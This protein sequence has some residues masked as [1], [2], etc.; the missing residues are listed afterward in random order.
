M[1]KT[2][3]HSGEVYPLKELIH[4]LVDLLDEGYCTVEI[5]ARNEA[6]EPEGAEGF[7]EY[8]PAGKLVVS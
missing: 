3:I 4:Q 2:I 6:Y 1:G 7:I 8:A 5:D